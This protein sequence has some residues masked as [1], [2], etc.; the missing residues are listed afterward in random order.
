M[1]KMLLVR[2]IFT[3]KGTKNTKFGKDN[4]V[5]SLRVLRAFVVKS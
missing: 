1:C 5:F 4:L 2:K 3:T